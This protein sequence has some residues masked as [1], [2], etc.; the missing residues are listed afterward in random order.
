MRLSQWIGA[1]FGV[2]QIMMTRKGA[3]IGTVG[4]MAWW[5]GQSVPVQAATV[6]SEVEALRS[7]IQQQQQLLEQQQRQLETQQQQLQSLM[8]RVDETS[9]QAKQAEEDSHQVKA[10]AVEAAKTQ[11]KLT[12]GT[13]NRP[14]FTSADGR[15]SISLTSILNLDVGGY[16]YTANSPATST[17]SLKSG[18]NARRARI[19]VNGRFLGDWT[20]DLQYDFGNFDDSLTDTN[21]PKSG[22]KS[23]YVSYTGLKAVVFDFGYLSVPYTLDQATANV[24]YMFME[25]PIPQALAIAVA[26]GDSRSAFGA[27][28]FNDRYWVGAYVTGP[29]AGT[30]HTTS[31][32]VGGTARATYQVID[33][34]NGNLHVGLDA[35][36]LF[37]VAGGH[38]L[39]FTV[40]PEI[41]I[42]PTA[43]YGLT[44]GSSSNFL[45]SG[46]VYSAELAAE[47][48][49]LF[50]QG[51]YF[52]YNFEREGLSDV[53]FNGGYVQGSWTLTGE[54]RPYRQ[55]S[56]AYGRISPSEPFSVTEGGIGAWEIAARVSQT[57]LNDHF[58]LG[59]VNTA[60]AV[61][62]GT[63]VSWTLGLNW[64]ANDNVMLRVD[65]EHGVFGNLS[66]NITG[67]TST[68]RDTG[69][70]LSAIAAR[71]QVTF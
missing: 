4:A 34:P 64:Y 26:G 36:H 46:T 8:S 58:T 14:T 43:L 48:K 67:K 19:G 32:Q 37:K 68:Q 41:S 51:E 65:Y 57:D 35:S 16:G 27:R 17:Q 39:N 52:L 7:Q 3:L 21:A 56:G 40:E 63:E 31:E 49:S 50:L 5:A 23:A 10:Q 25:H 1:I 62:G 2:W 11:P 69:S 59:T 42:D 24:D 55:A 53:N 45:R 47:Y 70:H 30:S 29:K 12:M 15:N 71:L 33:E 13:N 54:H 61:N 9:A 44:L 66:S 20:Y 60:D 22:I 6:N 28:S 38:T 18:F